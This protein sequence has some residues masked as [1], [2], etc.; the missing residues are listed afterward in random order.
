MNVIRILGG[1][2]RNGAEKY[3]DK[4]L[5]KNDPYLVKHI[6]YRFKNLRESEPGDYPK[7]HK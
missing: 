3:F 1:E 2:E 5:A 4:T 6:N 7:C